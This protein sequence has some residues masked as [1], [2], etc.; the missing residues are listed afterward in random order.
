MGF[1]RVLVIGAAAAGTIYASAATFGKW[2]IPTVAHPQG[3]RLRQESLIGRRAMV[4]PL[5]AGRTHRGGGL[6][7]GK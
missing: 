5:R 4:L 2:G 1:L 6:S 7:G 3:V